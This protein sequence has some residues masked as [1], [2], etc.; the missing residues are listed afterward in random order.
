MTLEIFRNIL[1]YTGGF[2]DFKKLLEILRGFRCIRESLW[3]S[4]K[5]RDALRYPRRTYEY[6]GESRM[7]Q[8]T[9]RGYRTSRSVPKL[10]R[11]SRSF[12]DSHRISM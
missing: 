9:Q 11:S 8:E 4:T 10:P 2:G 5:L 6:V 3:G 7:L 1:E 12:H